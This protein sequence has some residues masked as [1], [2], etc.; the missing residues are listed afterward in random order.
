MIRCFNALLLAAVAAPL[1]GQG[2]LLSPPMSTSVTISGKKLQVDYGA[3]SMRGRKVMGGLVPYGEVWC[4]GANDATTLITEADLDIAGLKVPKG[5]YT[6]WTI[7]EKTDWTLIVNKQTGQWHT[8]YN[9]R[10]DLGR[11]KISVKPV[12]TP[13]ERFRIELAQNGPN[14]GTLSLI[15][16]MTEAWAPFS[17]LR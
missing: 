10:W 13:V 15:W 9:Q 17:V 4:A 16:E 2:R 1:F 14:K 6:L 8:E 12:A 11:V 3:P 5:S 7:P